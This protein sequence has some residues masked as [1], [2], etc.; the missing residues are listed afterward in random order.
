MGSS[1]QSIIVRAVTP[2]HAEG[3]QYHVLP[4]HDPLRVVNILREAAGLPPLSDEPD[5][6]AAAPMRADIE[7]REPRC[8][9]C[10]DEAVRLSSTSCWTGTGSRSIWAVARH[11]WSPTQISCVTWS[12]STRVVT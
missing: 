10:R 5:N 6:R 4:T 2:D 9:I 11:T 3:L 8:R 1:V 7:R 12:P